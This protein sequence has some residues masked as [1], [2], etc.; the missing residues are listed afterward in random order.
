MRKNK[1]VV[2]GAAALCVGMLGFTGCNNQVMGKRDY[3]PATPDTAVA[4]MPGEVSAPPVTQ[5]PVQ[6]S[7]PVQQPPRNTGYKPME[8]LTSAPVTSV[9]AGTASGAAVSGAAR[10]HVVKA[11]DTVGH[12]ARQYGV[13]VGA[14]M[15]AND[16]DEAKAR[17]I[18]VGRKLVIPAGGAVVAKRGRGSKSTAAGATAVRGTI[19]SDGTYTVQ[20]GD[21]P[22]K[23]ARKL[24]V[25]ESE[26]MKANNLTAESAK[27]LQV[28]Q[29]LVV[30]GKGAKSGAAAAVT[31]PVQQVKPTEEVVTAP[32]KKDPLDD[33]L[34]G[35]DVKNP[36]ASQPIDVTPVQPVDP[37]VPVVEEGGV[38]VPNTIPIIVDED[39]TLEAFAA[40][41]KTTADEIRKLNE[42]MVPA[43]G[44]LS[45]NLLLMIP[46]N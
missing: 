42:G 22:G 16:L 1:T 10:T 3:V 9:P 15:Q 29:K 38:T 14:V 25:R 44:K 5:L 39:T 26:L 24:G 43:D 45:K 32:E 40:K 13:S 41:H 33:V 2:L 36:P 30:P 21:F 4:P 37:T 18:Q 20:S 31:K 34:A 7:Q 17:R 46:G 6:P 28:G 12:I 27:R 11:G 8:K 23:I 19:N 35:S